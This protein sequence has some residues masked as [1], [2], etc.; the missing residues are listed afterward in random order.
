[1]WF[2]LL[3]GNTV[4]VQNIMSEIV[5]G[6]SD[7]AAIFFIRCSSLARTSSTFPGRTFIVDVPAAFDGKSSVV[8]IHGNLRFL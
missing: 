7:S 8:T 6:I 5:G 3:R 1:M 2:V 4:K